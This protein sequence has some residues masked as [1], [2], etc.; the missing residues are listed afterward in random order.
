[1]CIGVYL[2]RSSTERTIIS[3]IITFNYD[4]LAD[5][6][7]PN[8]DQC[9]SKNSKASREAIRVDDNIARAH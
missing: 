3:E 6:V 2:R 5:I 4:V 7:R 8:A 9:P 1:M